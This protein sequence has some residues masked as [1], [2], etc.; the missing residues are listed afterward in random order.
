MAAQ[1]PIGQL[2]VE[3]DAGPDDTTVVNA[4]GEV[5]YWSVSTFREALFL[6]LDQSAGGVVVDLA[7]IGFIGADGI[8]ALLAA[9]GEAH[10]RG[11]HFALRSPS[12]L[13]RRLLPALTLTIDLPIDDVDRYHR[14]FAEPVSPASG[15][16]RAKRAPATRQRSGRAVERCTP[17]SCNARTLF[18]WT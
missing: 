3:L 13:L 10:R 17:V 4:I 7:A 16:P 11:R 18:R 8:G 12:P 2:W 1:L 14:A 9:T 15:Y 6:A 5:T